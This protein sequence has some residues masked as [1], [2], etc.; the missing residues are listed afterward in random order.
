MTDKFFPWL[1]TAGE[2]RVVHRYWNGL[3]GRNFEICAN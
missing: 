3:A 2:P 1:E